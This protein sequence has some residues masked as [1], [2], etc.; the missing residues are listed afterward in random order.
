MIAPMP[1]L[2]LRQED[3]DRSPRLRCGNSRFNSI[4]FCGKLCVIIATM[5]TG[6]HA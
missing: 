4:P 6:L 5:L 3:F 2:I 1:H